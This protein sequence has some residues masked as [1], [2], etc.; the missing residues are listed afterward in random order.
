MR[1]MCSLK[2]ETMVWGG[3]GFQ[4]RDPEMQQKQAIAG[5]L[6]STKAVLP[7]PDVAWEQ[8]NDCQL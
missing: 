8:S 1:L 7:F 6:K 4:F 5:I 2:T 3:R